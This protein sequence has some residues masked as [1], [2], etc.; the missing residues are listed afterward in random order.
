MFH[1]DLTMKLIWILLSL[2]CILEPDDDSAEG[3]TGVKDRTIQDRRVNKAV[4]LPPLDAL[5]A[6]MRPSVPCLF[7]CGAHL[8]SYAAAQNHRFEKTTR[9]EKTKGKRR[10]KRVFELEK[11]G[12]PQTHRG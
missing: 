12:E 10:C 3:D 4:E 9:F 6:S 1:Y 2:G 5:E 7:N 11:T 8:R